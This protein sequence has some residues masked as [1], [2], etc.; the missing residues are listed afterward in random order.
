MV[1]HILENSINCP[2]PVPSIFPSCLRP[3]F[4]YRIHCPRT[5]P[6]PL[7]IAG[8]TAYY[9]FCISTPKFNIT[10]TANTIRQSSQHPQQRLNMRHPPCGLLLTHPEPTMLA[11]FLYISAG[12]RR[13]ADWVLLCRKVIKRNITLNDVINKPHCFLQMGTTKKGFP[14]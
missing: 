3:R 5:L 6:L 7:A 12:T 4:P 13:G 2:C 1:S 9:I 11:T 14:D 8:S 10:S